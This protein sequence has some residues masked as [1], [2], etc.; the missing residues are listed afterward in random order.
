M[1]GLT[2]LQF[3][4]VSCHSTLLEALLTACFCRVKFKNKSRDGLLNMMVNVEAETFHF[5]HS[6]LEA[7]RLSSGPTQDTQ[8]KLFWGEKKPR[9]LFEFYWYV[10]KCMREEL[11]SHAVV[12]PVT[13]C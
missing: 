12:S 4:H 7:G 6:K 5:K 11:E 8:Q 13:R 10:Y 3:M 9:K 1:V 2:G